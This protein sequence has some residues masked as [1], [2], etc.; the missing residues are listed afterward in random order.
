M[1]GLLKLAR[2]AKPIKPLKVK[3]FDELIDLVNSSLYSP[4]ARRLLERD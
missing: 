4:R 1:K 3:T 2:E